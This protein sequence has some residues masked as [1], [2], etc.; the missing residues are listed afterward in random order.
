[1]ASRD[2][3]VQLILDVAADLNLSLTRPIDVSQGEGAALF[4]GEGVLDSLGFVSLVVAVEQALD[5]IG[6]SVILADERALSQKSSPFRT[7][8]SLADY[9]VA[10]SSAVQA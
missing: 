4:G 8:G 5:E 9:V 1:M 10:N 3:V 2:Q 6:I 7:V